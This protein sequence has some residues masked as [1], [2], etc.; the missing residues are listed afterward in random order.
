MIRTNSLHDPF[1]T[2]DGI[3]VL[4]TRYRPRGVRKQDETRDAWV[5]DLGPG[6]GLHADFYGKRGQGNN[7]AGIPP[8]IFG[9]YE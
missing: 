3:R 6:R 7:L 4:V 2:E 8:K 1:S 5:K 9:G